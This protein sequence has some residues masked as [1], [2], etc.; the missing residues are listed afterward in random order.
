[1]SK[2]ERVYDVIDGAG[3]LGMRSGQVVAALLSADMPRDLITSLIDDLRRQGRIARTGPPGQY[4]YRVTR[5]PT[6]LD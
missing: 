2:T 5:Q 1:M 4:I 3:D 6:P